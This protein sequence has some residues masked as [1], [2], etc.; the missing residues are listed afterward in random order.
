MKKFVL[1]G[2]A[3]L[4]IYAAD[5]FRLGVVEVRANENG[6]KNSDLSVAN[7][8]QDDMSKNNIKDIPQI[9]R[10]APGVYL[11]KQGSRA[12]HNI[13]VRGFNSRRVPVFIDG[14]P[15][16]VPYDANMDLG[17]FST[18]DVSRVDI[19]KGFNSVLYRPNT[20]GGAINIVSKRPSKEL[21]GQLRYGV[22]FGSSKDTFANDV[23]FDIA[24]KQELFYIQLGGS[25]MD[26]K[27][28]QLSK[29]Y[30]RYPASDE[31]GKSADNSGKTDKK[32]SL[33]LGYT[34]N[35]TDEYVLAFVLQKA[36]KDQPFYAGRYEDAAK[37]YWRWPQWD[38][39]SVYLLTHTAFDN[40]YLKTKS[41]YDTF[42]NKLNAYD[43]TTLKTQNKNFAFNSKYED[44]S[45]GFGAEIGYDGDKNSIKL[46]TNY[47][48]DVHKEQNLA[49]PN[50]TAEPKQTYKDMTYSFGVE[51]TYA[52][53][54]ATRVILAMSYDIKDAKKAQDYG[55][56]IKKSEY[57]MYDFEVSKQTAFNY[58]TALRHSFSG[59]DELS[60]SYA[61][62]SYF[63]SMKER[64]TKG[65]P[66]KNKEE[67][68]PNPFLKPEI[69][70]HYEIAYGK[71]FGDSVRLDSALF[72]S[73]VKNSIAQVSIGNKKLQNKNH[74]DARYAG[75]EL[76]LS[77]M[78]DSLDIGANYTYMSAKYKNK[79][80]KIYDISKHKGFLWTD[81]K[82]LPSLS[83]YL[84]WELSSYRYSSLGLNGY[85]KTAGFGVGNAKFIYAPIKSLVLEAGV[86]NV[87]DKNYAYDDGYYEEG[88]VFFSNVT[89]KF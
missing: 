89:Y 14:I 63:A 74:D 12:E 88:R 46:S 9:A 27:G 58:Q 6:Y 35:Q 76:S 69:A 26:T 19:S 59:D 31:D 45:A 10:I 18:F 11:Q 15:V 30:K 75:L 3:G 20:L 64:Y 25:Y 29:D 1:I 52:I 48:Y 60:I 2:M 8:Y 66:R 84:S 47:K 40:V 82:I 39:Q 21:E 13:N 73:N 79:P 28:I 51:N 65:L 7:I 37:K 34:P 53:S 55:E 38:K 70:H 22:R 4:A 42:E 41:Y 72:Y 5:T 54:D 71:N 50:K 77:Y 44:Y 16:Y 67:K 86:M 68:I 23:S 17:R 62:K 80:D 49:T 83:L 24:T 32:I 43:D 87:F 56:Y 57:V 85:V 81:V 33:K 36:Q 61:K 78:T